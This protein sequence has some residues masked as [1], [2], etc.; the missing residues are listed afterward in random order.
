MS[1]RREFGGGWR[2]ARAL[3]G[4]FGG[5]L[6]LKGLRVRVLPL[7]RFPLSARREMGRKL[8]GYD[9]LILAKNEIYDPNK[10]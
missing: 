5:G 8:V 10:K 2:G 9:G 7:L 3:T 6:G 4:A 1:Y